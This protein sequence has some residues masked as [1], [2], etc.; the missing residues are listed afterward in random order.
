MSNATG[1]SNAP[2][3]I[4]GR[5][6]VEQARRLGVHPNTLIRHVRKGK[7]LSDGTVVR[8]R[9]TV[10]PGGYYLHDADLD[11]FFAILTRD[12]LGDPTPTV[13]SKIAGSKAHED[14]DAALAAAGW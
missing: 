12:K 11:E 2:P 13:R 1:E 4:L 3:S 14:A 8:P 6:L 7:R 5:R 9:A 10:A